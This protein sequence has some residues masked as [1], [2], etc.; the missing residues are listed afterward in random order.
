[1][2]DP[3]PLFSVFSFIGFVVALIPLPWHFQA[4]NA[5]TCCYMIWVSL[6]C[7]IEFVNSVVWH[8]NAINWAPVW[9]DI[10]SKFL[11]GAGVG[12]PASSLCIIRRL[13][14]IAT[15]Q[16]VSITRQD[17]RRAL[18]TD[19]CIAIGIPVL[20]MILHYV[21]QGHRFDILEDVGCFPTIYNTLAAYFIVFMWPV[22]LGCISFIYSALTLRAFYK[23]RL[24]FS[25][26][27]T[28][29][30]SLNVSR[31]LRLMMLAVIEMMC[32]IPI[33]IYSMYISTQGVQ[34]FPY[35][36]WANVHYQFSYVEQVPSVIWQ[37]DPSYLVSVELTHW[38]FPI[39]AILFFALFG[40]A[41]EAQK[42]YRAVFF[43]TANR[44][45]YAPPVKKSPFPI[46]PRRNGPMQPNALTSVGSLPVYV[47]SYSPSTPGQKHRPDSLMSSTVAGDIDLEKA[48][49]SPY[50]PEYEAENRVQNFD[51]KVDI[52]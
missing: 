21:V 45:G 16:S 14:N 38:L 2:V 6:S 42:N 43:W 19:L 30:T 23:R 25:E 22:L 47:A 32:T 39:C 4:W 11:L 13:Y 17:K 18:I 8:G 51:E 33:G 29:S 10:S 31:Y 52:F 26:F 28:S 50:L 37:S 46:P 15:V 20:V 12:I 35:I 1:M 40:F 5:G 36:S 7:L 27:I 48:E 9:C 41:G 24:Q 49:P 34:L 44:V 3:Y